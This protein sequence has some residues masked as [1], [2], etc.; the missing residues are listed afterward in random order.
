MES[1]SIPDRAKP[2]PQKRIIKYFFRFQERPVD[3]PQR[4]RSPEIPYSKLLNPYPR[5]HISG[6]YRG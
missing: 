6:L 4:V 3:E 5:T 1:P 2:S